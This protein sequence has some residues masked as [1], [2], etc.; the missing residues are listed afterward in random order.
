MYSDVHCSKVDV[1]LREGLIMNSDVQ[2]SN[3]KVML[4]GYT[5]GQ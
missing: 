5:H 2:C 1:R 4:R 3:V